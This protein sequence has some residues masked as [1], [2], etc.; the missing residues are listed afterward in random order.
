MSFST[1]TTVNT[2]IIPA[3]KIQ[4]TKQA[5]KEM[6]VSNRLRFFDPVTDEGRL[7]FDDPSGD[8][9]WLTEAEEM[10][11]TIAASGARGDACFMTGDDG[12]YYWGIRF[13]GDLTFTMLQGHI[14]YRPK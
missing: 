9:D 14:V 7:S 4:V 1:S 12:G 10:A 2:V 6:D 3:S 5:V 11:T 13:N 8:Y